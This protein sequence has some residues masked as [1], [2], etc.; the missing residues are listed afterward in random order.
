MG[1]SPPHFCVAG[2]NPAGFG[3]CGVQLSSNRIKPKLSHLIDIYALRRT[4][5]ASTLHLS[6]ALRSPTTQVKMAATLLSRKA[7][8][9]ARPG[10]ASRR[11]VVVVR[12]SAEQ[13]QA[14]AVEETINAVSVE[15][16]APVAVPVA[17]AAAPAAPSLFGKFACSRSAA[18]CADRLDLAH[19]SGLWTLCGHQVPTILPEL[20]RMWLPFL[21]SAEAMSFS[22]PVG[23]G[24]FPVPPSQ[25]GSAGLY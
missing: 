24:E 20:S 1:S 17:A 4:A 11:S 19:C 2:V 8:A 5:P 18:V 6:L 9:S 10:F 7:V 23:P 21:S 15:K 12:A 16:V 25:L 13:P 14:P 3:L 22:N